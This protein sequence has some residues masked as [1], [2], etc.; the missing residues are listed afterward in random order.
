MA[1]FDKRTLQDWEAQ[2]EKETKGLSADELVWKTAEG[3]GIKAL[4]TADDLEG[5]EHIGT[6]PGFAPFT[7]GPRATMYVGRPWTLRQYAGFSTAEESNAFY[8]RN[9]SARRASRSTVSRT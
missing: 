6:L 5:L 4:Y 3:I 2:V 7:R 9:L 1:E 8:K